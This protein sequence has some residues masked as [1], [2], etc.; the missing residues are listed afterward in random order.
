MSLIYSFKFDIVKIKLRAAKK[1]KL[2]FVIVNKK[3]LFKIIYASIYIIFL[4]CV[5]FLQYLT[6]ILNSYKLNFKINFNLS[7]INKNEHNSCSTIETGYFYKA[8]F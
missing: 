8:I 6:K 3:F 7:H 5:C 1:L 2:N 4:L